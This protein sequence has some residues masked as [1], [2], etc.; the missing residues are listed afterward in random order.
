MIHQHALVDPHAK[1]GANVTVG[2]FSV[3]GP[4][5]EIGENTWIGSHVVINGHTQIGRNNRIF[6][7]ASIGEVNQDKKYRDEPTQ[8][9]IGD[10]NVIREGVTIH[11]GTIQD[12]GITQIGNDNL[13]MAYVHI[14][15]DCI[16]K[17]HCIFA[18]SAQVAG[19]VKV[20]DYVI[21][22]GLCGVHQFVQIGAHA[23]ISHA[24]MVGKD[25]PPFVMLTG[26]AD[27]TVCGLN[28]E[29]LKRR[30]FTAEDITALKRA[31]KI[32]YRQGLRLVDAIESLADAAEENPHVAQFVTFLKNTKRG[33]VR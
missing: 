22:S 25:V 10:N 20:D 8:V 6:Q 27:V 32:I 31:Y 19:H 5:V 7:F 29:G 33:I 15:H 17:N 18:N 4:D 9:I 30:G 21:I 1:I 3:I 14:A 13:F 24:S 23:F 12:K 28:T 2:P 11:R 16:I 26:G